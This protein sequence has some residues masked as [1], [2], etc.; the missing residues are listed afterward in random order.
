MTIKVRDQASPFS[1]KKKIV[2]LSIV[3][4]VTLLSVVGYMAKQKYDSM[5]KATSEGL[6]LGRTH[7]KMINQSN[8]ILGLKMKYASCTT[9]ECELSANG[10]ISGCIKAAEKD[11]FCTSVPNIKE[12]DKAL[13]W[14]SKTCS[15]NRLGS[16]K[17]HKYMH[18]FIS[19]CTE[20]NESRNLS[21]AEV[22]ENSFKK[23]LKKN[24]H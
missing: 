16:D 11:S 24:F 20:Q 7:G 8:C 3:A 22:F 18:K 1:S 19:A 13:S 2:A 12:T 14:V 9:T 17:C 10:Y 4:V 21:K 15:A 23:G 6:T 5:L